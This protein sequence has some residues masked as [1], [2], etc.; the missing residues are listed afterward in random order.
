VFFFQNI[1]ARIRGILIWGRKAFFFI[2]MDLG[3]YFTFHLKVNFRKAVTG[4][5]PFIN[6]NFCEVV[7]QVSIPTQVLSQKLL[8]AFVS[9]CYLI[10]EV[11]TCSQITINLLLAILLCRYLSD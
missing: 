1:V 2:Y 10:Q 8:R 5:L 9:G 7:V 3:I 11:T 4:I 6:S